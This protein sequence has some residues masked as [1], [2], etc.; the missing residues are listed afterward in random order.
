MSITKTHKQYS[1]R[2][3]FLHSFSQKNLSALIIVLGVGILGVLTILF[4][5]ADT[6][7]GVDFVLMC[8]P[9]GQTCTGSSTATTSYAKSIQNWYASVLG[10]GR[11]F[12]L[13]SVRVAYAP[14]ATSYYSDGGTVAG[15]ST[16]LNRVTTDLGLTNSSTNPIKTQVLMGFQV[17]HTSSYCGIS[18]QPGSVSVSDQINPADYCRSDEMA[19]MM[20]HELG[21]SF[22]LGHISDANNLMNPIPCQN[23]SV[24]LTNCQMN[25]TERSYLLNNYG[26]WFVAPTTASCSGANQLTSG[27]SLY[28]GQYIISSNCYKLVLQGDGNLVIYNGSGT[29]IWN[30]GTNGKGGY[31]AVFQSDGNFVIYT[32][33]GSAIWN[34][35]TNGHGGVRIVMQTDGNLVIYNSSGGALW[36]SKGG[37]TY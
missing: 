8:P 30:T 18:T 34:T 28:A 19:A 23:M 6:P 1:S 22:G 24:T 32:S 17:F 3:K 12:V 15:A 25:S 26:A 14:H 35:A 27:Q 36:S 9:Q 33:G 7:I 5:S 29:V 2:P 37:R 10:S 13:H 16:T 21:H 11:T 4:S 20:A 31:R